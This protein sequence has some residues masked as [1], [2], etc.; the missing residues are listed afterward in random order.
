MYNRNLSHY[1]IV[2]VCSHILKVPFDNRSMGNGVVY[3]WSGRFRLL[4]T[5]S[6]CDVV[7]HVYVV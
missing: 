7:S 5:C 3:V 2:T 6:S 4:Q 1:N